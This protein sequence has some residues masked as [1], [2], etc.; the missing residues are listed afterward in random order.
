MKQFCGGTIL[1]DHTTSYIFN[2]H[3]TN[4]IS[5]TTVESK[6][7]GESKFGEFGFKIKQYAVS[8][9]LFRST[10]LVDSYAVQL[11]LPISHSCLATNHQV[12][13]GRHIQTI[14]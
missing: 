7:Y 11:Q 10:I 14:F 1:F 4:N 6:N 13:A 9:H 3:L 12:L 2:N 5:G 8:N